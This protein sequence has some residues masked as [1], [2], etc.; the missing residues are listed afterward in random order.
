MFQMLHRKATQSPAPM[1]MRGVAF[2]RISPTARMSWNEPKT[3]T[4]TAS[5]P[6]KP[7]SQ[8]RRAPQASATETAAMGLTA[9]S[10]ICES[11]R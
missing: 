8:R 2:R 5:S 1:R 10:A 3:M 4:V 6:L 9:L 7:L 11:L